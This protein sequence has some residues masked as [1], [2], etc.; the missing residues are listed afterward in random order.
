MD[1]VITLE[2]GTNQFWGPCI[3]FSFSYILCACCSYTPYEDHN[4]ASGPQQNKAKYKI[5][6]WSPA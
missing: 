1:E 5:K 4:R 3:G 6:S 2:G